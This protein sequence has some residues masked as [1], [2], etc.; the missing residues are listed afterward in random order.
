VKPERDRRESRVTR[1][2]IELEPEQTPRRRL[3][4]PFRL[5]GLCLVLVVA[6]TIWWGVRRGR[7]VEDAGKINQQVRRGL[8]ALERGQF[9]EANRELNAAGDALF[10]LGKT[11]PRSRRIRQLARE[12]RA[13]AGLVPVP[14]LEILEQVDSAHREGGDWRQRFHDQGGGGWIIVQAPVELAGADQLQGAGEFRVDY[15]FLLGDREIQLS[16]RLPLLAQLSRDA[17]ESRPVIFAAKLETCRLVAVR[18]GVMSWQVILQ[19]DSIFLWTELAS[20]RHLGFLSEKIQ[21]EEQL[22]EL[23]AHQARVTGLTTGEEDQ[24]P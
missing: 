5:V 1:T 17:E 18:P 6:T 14:L 11:D 21:D 2:A 12:A 16:G 13:A 10:R 19:E 22:G 20:I 23:L 3:V 24:Q 15:P 7:L 8:E 9:D 4:T